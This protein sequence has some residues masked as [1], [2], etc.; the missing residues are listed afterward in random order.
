MTEFKG[1]S[2]EKKMNPDIGDYIKTK[3]LNLGLNLK[4][5]QRALVAMCIG[6]GQGIAIA[7]ES[8]T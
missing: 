4:G 1:T 7:L 3:R 8:A 6:V 5:V 2:N